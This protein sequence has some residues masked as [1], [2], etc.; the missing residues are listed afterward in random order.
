[1]SKCDEAGAEAG[2]RLQIRGL[3]PAP[4]QKM[5]SPRDLKRM[6]FV[7]LFLAGRVTT[8]LLAS[9]IAKVAIH[10]YVAKDQF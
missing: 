1:M 10:N 6:D 7:A 8:G 5:T 3:G 2:A 4:R 9:G